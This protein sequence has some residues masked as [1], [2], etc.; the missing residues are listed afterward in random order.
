ML[1]GTLA[2]SDRAALRHAGYRDALEAA[3]I[4]AQPP[5]E[6]DFNAEALASAELDRLLAAHRRVLQQ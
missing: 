2:A 3:G 5:V 4:A 1:T 6:I